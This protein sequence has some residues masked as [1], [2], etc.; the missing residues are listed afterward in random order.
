M[1]Q[2]VLAKA[3]SVPHRGNVA[4]AA[5]MIAKASTAPMIKLP[6][7]RDATVI[8]S[9]AIAKLAVAPDIFLHRLRM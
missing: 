5:K 8:T 3:S 4:S 2:S 7:H 9:A 1:C 6:A